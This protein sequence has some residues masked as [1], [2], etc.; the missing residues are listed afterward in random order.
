MY[1]YVHIH[2]PS[3]LS[4]PPTHP[5]NLSHPSSSS[6][7][8]RL[9]SPCYVTIILAICFIQSSVYNASAIS[10]LIPPCLSPVVSVS[11][12]ST[13]VPLFLSRK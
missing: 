9:D 3:L 11:P 8:A 1:V 5:T 13:S 10:Q 7:S 2:I 6:Q 4:L 12:F